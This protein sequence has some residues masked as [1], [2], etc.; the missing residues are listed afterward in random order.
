MPAKCRLVLYP[1]T[2]RETGKVK[3]LS[4]VVKLCQRGQCKCHLGAVKFAHVIHAYR[5]GACKQSLMCKQMSNL[6]VQATGTCA[7]AST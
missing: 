6:H 2:N 7:A 5:I 4:K 3:N 1:N